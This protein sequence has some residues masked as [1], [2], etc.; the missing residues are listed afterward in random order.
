MHI[1]FLTPEYPHPV[2]GPSGGLGTSIKNLVEQLISKGIQVTVVISGQKFSRIFKENNIDFHIV[3]QKKY[4]LFGFYLYRKYLARYLN[5]LIKSTGVDLIEAPDWTGITA[6]MNLD[7]PLIIRFHGTD[8]YFCKLEGRQ[9]KWKNYHF[10][11]LALSRADELLSVS[12]FTAEV[13]SQIFRIKNRVTIIPNAVNTASF[14]P[15]KGTDMVPNTILYFGSIIRKKGILELAE[16]FNKVIDKK[17][18]ALLVLVGKDVLDIL[19]NRSSL[20]LLKERLSSPALQRTKYIRD[21]SYEEIKKY[22]A[23]ASVVVLPSFAEALPMTWLEAMAMEKA[24][25]TSNIGWAN[26]IMLNGKTGFT[27]NPRNHSS[28][29]DKILLLM[30]DKSLAAEM[31]KKAREHVENEFSGTVVIE[32]NLAFYKEVLGKL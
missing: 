25:V 10:E 16:I 19:E 3:A 13:T 8:A 11:K 30:N 6:F 2:T 9:Q 1:A 28:Y 32:K 24:L 21:V 27:E 7:V 29:A 18:D 20:D 14:T 4:P 5:N 12:K 31:G 26:E 22:I 17:P 23:S 15:S